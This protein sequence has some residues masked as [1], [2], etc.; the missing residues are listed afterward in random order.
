MVSIYVVTCIASLDQTDNMTTLCNRPTL[1]SCLQDTKEIGASRAPQAD[2]D[3]QGGEDLMGLWGPL[4]S[5]APRS[6]LLDCVRS[7]EG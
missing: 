3:S 6:V 5:Q 4:E 1:C 7:K 2:Q